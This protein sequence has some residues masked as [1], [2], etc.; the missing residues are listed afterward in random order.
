MFMEEKIEVKWKDH[1]DPLLKPALASSLLQ[2]KISTCWVGTAFPAETYLS[3]EMNFGG[4]DVHL[5]IFWDLSSYDKREDIWLPL[6]SRISKMDPFYIFSNNL[7]Q[8]EDF[9]FLE[10]SLLY[11]HFLLLLI[12]MLTNL[13]QA[14]LKC[15]FPFMVISVMK[16]FSWKTDHLNLQSHM[17]T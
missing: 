2:G 16:D 15:V 14:A 12:A 9:L 5:P 3:T 6:G 4:Y 8:T 10:R 1:E 17:V 13:H 7:P 11:K